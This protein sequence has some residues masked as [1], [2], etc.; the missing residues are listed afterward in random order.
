MNR[1]SAYANRLDCTVSR[2]SKGTAHSLSRLESGFGLEVDQ[3]PVRAL[4][5]L[6][7]S[8]AIDRKSDIPDLQNATLAG[9]VRGCPICHGF[10]VQDQVVGLISPLREGY[11][12]ALF[13]R[14]YTRSPRWFVQGNLEEID[15]RELDSSSG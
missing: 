7:A 9:A 4:E 5:V 15:A 12:H 14:T 8:G 3:R 6:V 10:E 11:K 13:L 1:S 2:S